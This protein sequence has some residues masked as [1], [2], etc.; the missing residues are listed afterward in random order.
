MGVKITLGAMALLLPLAACHKE[1]SFDERYQQ[2]SEDAQQA[3]SKM[4]KD[5]HDRLRAAEV[6]GNG[7]TVQQQAHSD[8]SGQ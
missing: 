8:Q 6:A 3:A 5:L 1:K 2:Q 7:A 4:E